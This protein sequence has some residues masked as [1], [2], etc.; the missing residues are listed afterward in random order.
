M[1]VVEIQNMSKSFNQ[2]KV[3]DNIS[4]SISR[5]DIV[6]LLGPSGSGKSTTLRCATLLETMD[7]GNL[8]YL[9]GAYRWTAQ[10]GKIISSHKPEKTSQKAIYGL[11]FQNFKIPPA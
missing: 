3:L 6:A 8:L 10:D 2:N 11:V 7:S 4:F 1:N 5:G 9:D